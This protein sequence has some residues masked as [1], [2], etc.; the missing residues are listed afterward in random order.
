MRN[1]GVSLRTLQRSFSE[2]FQVS[3]CEYIKVRR[4]NAER[5]ALAASNSSLDSVTKV[6][7]ENGF[8]HLGRFAVD[9]RE[10]FEESPRETLTRRKHGPVWRA[11]YLAAS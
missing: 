3:P 4:L 5:L 7:V 9:Y 8:T 10:H 2:Y 6:A 11:G 1:T